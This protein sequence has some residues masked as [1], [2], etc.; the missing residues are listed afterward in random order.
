MAINTNITTEELDMTYGRNSRLAAAVAL[1]VLPVSRFTAANAQGAN[2]TQSAGTVIQEGRARAA[3][4]NSSGG[5]LITVPEDFAKLK[6]APGFLLDVEVFE[7][8]DYSGQF[9]VGEDGNITLPFA[10]PVHVAGDSPSAAQAKI[11]D[12]YQS[13]KVLNK[14]QVTSNIIQYVP[15][16]VNVLGEVATPGRLQVLA[17]HSLLDIISFAGGETGLAGGKV[18]VSHPEGGKSATT[19]YHYERNGSSTAIAGVTVFPGDTVTVPRAGIVYVMGAVTRPGGYIMQ[20]DGKLDLA[21]AI[22]MAMGTTL[23]ASTHHVLVIRRHPD[24]SF[25]QFEV[26]FSKV[27]KG[28]TPPPQ[29]QAEDIV[30]VPNSKM[31]ITLVDLQGLMTTAAEAAIY[32]Y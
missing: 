32:K 14:P 23:V 31:K 29:L 21:Q 17:P 11:A 22:S 9:R 6:I 24:G 30:F 25:S 13:S 10:G 20:E 8:P 4:S 5:G 19:E 7:E 27:T 12:A 28:E 16:I 3:S 2:I 18:D 15:G 26:P 1:C